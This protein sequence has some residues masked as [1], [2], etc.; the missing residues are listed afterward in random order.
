MI[1]P[2][3]AEA[4]DIGDEHRC[5]T[6]GCPC[7]HRFSPQTEHIRQGLERLNKAAARWREVVDVE[8]GDKL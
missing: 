2:D 7:Q 4:A 1:C 3:C 6:P 5:I 8:T